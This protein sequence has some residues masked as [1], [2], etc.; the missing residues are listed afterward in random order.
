MGKET[1]TYKPRENGAPDGRRRWFRFCRILTILV[2]LGASL[3]SGFIAGLFASVAGVLPKGE[4][5]AD[6]RPTTP[7]RILASDGTLLARINS[8]DQNRELVPINQMGYMINATLAIEDIRF[9]SHPGIDPRGIARALFR[10]LSSRH[11]REGA[12]TITQQLARNL[13]LTRDQKITRKLQEIILA[14]E[15]ERRYSKEEILETYLNQVYYGSN[16]FSVQSWGAQM[17]SRNYFGKDVRNLTL[18]EAA[19]LAGLPK[20]PRDY[21]PYKHPDEAKDRRNTVL[22]SMYTNNFISKTQYDAACDEPIKLAEEKPLVE[23]ADCHAPYF[24]RHIITTELKKIFGQDWER[25][26]YH[27]GVDVYTSLD[28][29]MQ[30][31][32][33]EAVTNGVEKNKFRN[34]DDGALI[35]IDPKTGLI[36]AMVGGTDYRKDQFNIVTQGHRQPGSAFK[37][38]D[39]TTAMLRGYTPDTTVFDRPGRYPSG[40]GQIWSPKN[41]DGRYYGALP[42]KKAMWLSRNAAAAGVAYDIGIK[43]IINTAHRMGIKYFLNPMLSTALGASVVV[44]MEICSAYGS[45]ANGGVHHPPTGV[46]RVTTSEGEVLYEYRANPQR[47]V[48][49]AI[50]DTMKVT[51]RGVIEHGTAMIARCP[52]PASGKTGTTNSYRD[53]WFIGY[54]DDLVAAVWVGNRSNEPMNRTFGGTVPAPI[55]KEF[56]LVAQPIMLAQHTETAG[57]LARINN[58]PDSSEG[59]ETSPS[60]YIEKLQGNMNSEAMRNAQRDNNSNGSLVDTAETVT[61]PGDKF[62]VTICQDSGLR[63]TQWCPDKVVVTYVKGKLPAP[64]TK[65]CAQHTGPEAVPNADDVKP[66][67]PVKGAKHEQGILISICAETGKIATPNCPHVLLRRFTHDAPTETC[68]L[69]GE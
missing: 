62:Q 31:V 53:A 55:W 59:L 11:S 15:L 49:T 40:S 4:A 52:F 42:L 69:H 32:A 14:L 61:K 17:A 5:L 56:M 37:A 68:P 65:Y 22:E 26:T 47:A 27:Y 63:A 23:M 41:S 30:K 50:A 25:L 19:L 6:I 44:P 12:S 20:N 51:M 54:T 7:T 10:D 2:L 34:I 45:L 33:E 21:N 39:Y 60:P 46:V 18:A 38:F 67:K 24:V 8:P 57:E 66:A 29:R 13:Y 35:A 3:F 58:L 16:R 43:N 48:P 1:I 28:P 9:F 36:K 64:P